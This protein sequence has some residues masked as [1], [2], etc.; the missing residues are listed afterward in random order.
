LKY[1]PSR[2]AEMNVIQEHIEDLKPI[3]KSKSLKRDI[4][5]IGSR[6]FEQIDHTILIHMMCLIVEHENEIIDMLGEENV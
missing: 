1:T 5:T 4:E 3:C 2:K 6:L